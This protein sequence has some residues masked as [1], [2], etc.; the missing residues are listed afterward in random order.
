MK[1][2]LSSKLVWLVG[3][4]VAFL[5]PIQALMIAT[6]TIITIDFIFGIL[7]AKKKGILINSKRMSHTLIKMLTYQL[8]IITSYLMKL[9]FIPIIPI[10]EI[11]SGFIGIVELLSISENFTVIT[12]KNFITYIR[13]IIYDKVKQGDRHQDNNRKQQ[14]IA[15]SQLVKKILDTKKGDAK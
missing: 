10:V 3:F 7:A 15:V 6:G 11:T 5:S 1:S 13:H 4:L 12:G 8:L 9:Y 14:E 2:W